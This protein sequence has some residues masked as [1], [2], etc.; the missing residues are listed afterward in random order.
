VVLAHLHARGVAAAVVGRGSEPD[1]HRLDDLLV[2]ALRDRALLHAVA[3][4]A[5]G[6]LPLVQSVAWRQPRRSGALI[7]VRRVARLPPAQAMRRQRRCATG[8]RCSSASVSA[9]CWARP[10]P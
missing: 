7:S 10:R 4:E 1:L 5:L 8:A 2:L 6:R 3:G 9:W